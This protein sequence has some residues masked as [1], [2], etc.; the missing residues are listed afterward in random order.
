[1]ADT[2]AVADE[3][4]RNINDTI[5][6]FRTSPDPNDV[7]LLAA[8]KLWADR[9]FP[10]LPEPSLTLFKEAMALAGAQL[11]AMFAR[12]AAVEAQA[13]PNIFNTKGSA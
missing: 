13:K 7:F 1:M 2:I 4:I 10:S 6:K 11:D 3:I 8:M 12:A 9:F 5:I